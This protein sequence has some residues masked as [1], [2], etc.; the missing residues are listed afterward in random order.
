MYNGIALCYI[1]FCYATWCGRVVYWPKTLVV[2]SEHYSL[3]HSVSYCMLDTW[4]FHSVWTHL[5][6]ILENAKRKMDSL[7]PLNKHNNN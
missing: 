1:Y 4:D 5:T 6:V 7:Q 3:M 2:I